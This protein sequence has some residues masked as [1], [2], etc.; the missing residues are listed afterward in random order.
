MRDGSV[1]AGQNTYFYVKYRYPAD[2]AARRRLEEEARKR[3]AEAGYADRVLGIH[4]QYGPRNWRYSAQ[5]SAAIEPQ[6]VYDNG[7]VTTFAFS[8]NQEMPAIYIENSDGTESRCRRPC[9]AISFWFMRLAASS[10]CAVGRTRSASSTKPIHPS[11]WI[12]A[13]TPLRPRSSAWSRLRPPASREGIMSD[14]E[15]AT[16]PGERGETSATHK[17]ETNPLVKR[18]SVVFA[19]VAFMGFAMW[20]MRQAPKEEAEQPGSNVIRQTTE[21]EPAKAEPEPVVLPV[22][23]IKLP[24]PAVAAEEAP[25]VDELLEAARRAP[26]MAFG[27]GQTGNSNRQP[28]GAAPTNDPNFIPVDGAFGGRGQG[29]TRI[30]AS[31]GC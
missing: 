26:V 20:S 14:T 4:E 15:N 9:R 10:S 3:A 2:E 5:G 8:D 22:P 23:E 18:G 21:F 29:E 19:I 7:K 11:A 1:D 30:S 31:T 6:S 16:I 25:A 12:R 24:T 28:T 27:G 13:R 17:K